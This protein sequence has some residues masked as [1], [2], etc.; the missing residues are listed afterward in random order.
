MN[1]NSLKNGYTG[2]TGYTKNTC[3]SMERKRIS[4]EYQDW[5]TRIILDKFVLKKWY[6]ISDISRNPKVFIETVKL[7]IDDWKFYW[8]ELSE[9]HQ[10]VRK[11][12]D[13]EKEYKF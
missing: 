2:Y 12:Y 5:V 3:E 1:I 11:V 10:L 8:I 6:K 13:I 4:E 7:L 9:D